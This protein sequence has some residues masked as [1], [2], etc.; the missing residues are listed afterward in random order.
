MTITN[1]YFPQSTTIPADTHIHVGNLCSPR[2]GEPVA[3]QFC[4]RGGYG[5]LTRFQSYD[6]ICMMY[7][8]DCG[9]LTVFPEAFNYSRTT[10]KYSAKFLRDEIGFSETEIESVKKLAKASDFGRDC[11]LYIQR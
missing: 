7:D 6:T 4:I 5:F 10:S 2:S 8:H 9:V 1:S 11:P 3:N